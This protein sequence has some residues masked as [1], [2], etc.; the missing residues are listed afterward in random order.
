MGLGAP[1]KPRLIQ[2]IQTKY[3]SKRPKWANWRGIPILR[4]V[5][6][7]PEFGYIVYVGIF[8]N[9]YTMTISDVRTLPCMYT[10]DASEQ[11]DAL[12]QA[13]LAQYSSTAP[14]E[15][16]IDGDCIRGVSSY[17]TCCSIHLYLCP[18]TLKYIYCYYRRQLV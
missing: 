5:T 17:V 13:P 10:Y 1:K 2:A 18:L 4:R 16:V 11:D 9:M 15:V 14:A 6:R 7:R 3:F 12:G 8:V